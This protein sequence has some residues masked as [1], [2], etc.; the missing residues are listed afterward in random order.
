MTRMALE[1][2]H[3]SL[4][5]GNHPVVMD[6]LIPY[7]TKFDRLV[8]SRWVKTIIRAEGLF[9]TGKYSPILP[10]RSYVLDDDKRFGSQQPV[11]LATQK[12]VRLYTT[13]I[14]SAALVT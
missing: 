11:L 9:D 1:P 5:L 8:L 13:T 3:A 4:L 7:P 12:R 10:S 14:Q 6:R 2:S